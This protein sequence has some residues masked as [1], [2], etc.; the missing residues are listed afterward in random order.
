MIRD[1]NSRTRLTIWPRHHRDLHSR[2]VYRTLLQ[3]RTKTPTRPFY[4]P[5]MLCSDLGIFILRNDTAAQAMLPLAAKIHVTAALRG[6]ETRPTQRDRVAKSDT[7]S[8]S[9]PPSTQVLQ[10]RRTRC[11]HP[12]RRIWS[13]G[14]SLRPP[15]RRRH[16][17]SRTKR[18]IAR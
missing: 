1:R 7:A 5:L 8:W 9:S 15:I 12:N 3:H 4:P 13:H 2:Q 18:W 6:G 17:R 16:P 11:V 14:R 10:P